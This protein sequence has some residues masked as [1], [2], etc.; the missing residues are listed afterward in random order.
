MLEKWRDDIKN[1]VLKSIP[2]NKG[3]LWTTAW[4]SRLEINLNNYLCSGIWFLEFQ[5]VFLQN[6][7]AII[8]QRLVTY[9]FVCKVIKELFKSNV[10]E[11]RDIKECTTYLNS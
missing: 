11:N 6:Y 4:I 3:K 7:S 10:C 8:T 2:K 1:I 9:F 5:K